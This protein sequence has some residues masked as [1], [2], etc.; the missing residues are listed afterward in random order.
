MSSLLLAGYSTAIV[1]TFMLV[2]EEFTCYR[3]ATECRTIA[4]SRCGQFVLGLKHKTYLQKVLH[5][6]AIKG[7]EPLESYFAELT[8]LCSRDRCRKRV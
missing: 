1:S 5:A 7:L 3:W 8:R 6:S 2:L 4:S